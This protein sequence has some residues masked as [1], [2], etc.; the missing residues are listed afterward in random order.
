MSL[1]KRQDMKAFDGYGTTIFLRVDL[2][3]LIEE[4]LSR[5]YFVHYLNTLELARRNEIHNSFL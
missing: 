5:V 2:F 1:F 3:L 4:L